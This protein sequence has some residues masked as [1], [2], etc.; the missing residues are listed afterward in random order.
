MYYKMY[1]LVKLSSYR[2]TTRQSTL[3]I[4]QSADEKQ[5]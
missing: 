4:K 3:R 5:S 1:N 2:N